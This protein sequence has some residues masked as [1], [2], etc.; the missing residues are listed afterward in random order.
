MEIIFV[1]I[2]AVALGIGIGFLLS[3]SGVQKYLTEIEILKSRISDIGNSHVAEISAIKSNSDEKL[4]IEKRNFQEQYQKQRLS[5]ESMLVAQKEAS[6]RAAEAQKKAAEDILMREKEHSHDALEALQGRFDETIAKMKEQLENV[7]SRMLK[8][9]QKEFESSSKDSV[10]QIVKPLEDTIRQMKEVVAENTLKH[11]EFGGVLNANIQTLL[12]HS[13][14]AKKS[15][16]RLADALRSGGKVQGDWGETVLTELLE[17]QGLKEGIHY[18]T[19]GFMRDSA[20]NTITSEDDRRLRP[21]VILH[22]DKTRDVIIDAKVSL[23]AYLDYVNAETEEVKRQSLKNHVISIEKHISELARKNYSAYVHPP[24]IRMNY[25]IMFVPN[26]SA[27]YAATSQK[28]DLW[29]KAMEQNVYIADEQTLYAALKIIDMTWRQIAQAENHEKVFGL[30]N[31]MLK[32]VGAF[33]DKYVTIGKKLDDATKS[34]NDGMMKLRDS[35][36]SI[37]QTC[38]KLINLGAEA[39]SKKGVPDELLGIS[40]DTEESNF[41]E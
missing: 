28:P 16:D 33:M 6:D 13:D 38:R 34:Y 18:E 7:T 2:V 24:K 41:I 40:P 31:E 36:Q 21:D 15:A 11:S 29:R 39:I 30:A 32:R 4:N 35:G 3:K 12:S 1:A 37:P 25:V 14:A 19:Q 26:T 5:Y 9:R 23:S 22:L 27:L 20:G 17:S 8:E 10:S